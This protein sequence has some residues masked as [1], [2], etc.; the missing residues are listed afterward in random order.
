MLV[1]EP[2]LKLFAPHACLVC[3]EEGVLACQMCWPQMLPPMPSRCYLC[4]AATRDFALCTLCR[5]KSKL[6]HVW[7]CTEYEAY[8]KKLVRVLKYHFATEAAKIMATAMAEVL[9]F[10]EPSRPLLVP[11]PTATSRRRTRGF[12]QSELLAKHIAA[13]TG[14]KMGS[15]LTRRGQSRQ[16]GS[17]KAQRLTQL[18]N[19]LVVRRPAEVKNQ[20]VIVVDDV[21]TTGATIEA[22]AQALRAAGASSVN[23][24]V[25]AQAQ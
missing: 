10:L 1:V 16:V 15:V 21:V 14:W 4:Q 8:A 25:F 2:L 20:H 7:V 5:R 24:V 23:A 6:R 19:A 9:P 3:G 17:K 13:K 12:D 22:A 11:I 18:Q